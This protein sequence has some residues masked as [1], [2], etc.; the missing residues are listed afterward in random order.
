MQR[1]PWNTETGDGILC[2]SIYGNCVGK[3]E[4]IVNAKE[5]A[6]S[7]IAALSVPFLSMP[8]NGNDALYSV[9]EAAA[10]RI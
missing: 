8:N 4:F 7:A 2:R 1:I 6:K 10:A 3:H 9:I 5:S